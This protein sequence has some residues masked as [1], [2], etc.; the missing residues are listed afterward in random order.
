MINKIKSTIITF[1]LLITPFFV[2]ATDP[3]QDCVDDYNQCYY[4][5]EAYLLFTNDMDEFFSDVAVCNNDYESCLSNA[6]N[7]PIGN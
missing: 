7:N 3:I 1:A 2:N 4:W 6:Q 5:A